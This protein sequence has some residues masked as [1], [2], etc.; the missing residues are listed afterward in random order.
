M[1]VWKTKFIVNSRENGD[2]Q[3]NIAIEKV[4]KI[5]VFTYLPCWMNYTQEVEVR[6]EQAR[7]AFDKI[8]KPV[9]S[10]EESYYPVLGASH[11]F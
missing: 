11:F 2:T 6:I 5:H 9:C 8:K 3:M 7:I 10:E 4:E 1:N